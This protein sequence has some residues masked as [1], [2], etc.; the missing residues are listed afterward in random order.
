MVAQY[1]KKERKLEEIRIGESEC[2]N[3]LYMYFYFS[4]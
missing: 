2:K 3:V 4:P 1:D